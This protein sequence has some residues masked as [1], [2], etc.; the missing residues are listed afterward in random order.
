MY[1]LKH[2][3]AQKGFTLTELMIAVA[4][5]MS[6]ISSVL[7][8]YLATYSGSVSTLANSK[9]SQ[10]MATVMNLMIE[11]IRRAGFSGAVL[12]PATNPFNQPATTALTTF[13]N[14]IDNN[15]LGPQA[16]TGTCLLYSYDRFPVGAPNGSVEAA[17]LFGFRLN[18]GAIEMRTTG[19]P[20]NAPTCAGVGEWTP[21]TDPNFIQIQALTFSLAFSECLNAR[22]PN[23]INDDEI[24]GA[25]NDEEYDCY[26]APFPVAGSNDKT[27]ETRQVDIILTARLANDNFV[28]MTMRQS[29]RVRNDLVRIR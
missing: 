22:E 1:S 21:L 26:D 5:G 11:D 23:S 20:A 8:G 19:V 2:S 16:T 12:A 27:V 13:D 15:Q 25:D 9:L 7:V 4:L 6:V 17:D 18:A 3:K 28:R 24:G 29:V 10:E 14:P